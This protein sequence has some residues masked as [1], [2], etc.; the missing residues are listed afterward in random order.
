MFISPKRKNT[1]LEMTLKSFILCKLDHQ[2]PKS[3]KQ[4]AA[5]ELET[6]SKFDLLKNWVPDCSAQGRISAKSFRLKTCPQG[7]LEGCKPF[8]ECP[9]WD[10]PIW[11]ALY[12]TIPIQYLIFLR[13]YAFVKRLSC[14]LTSVDTDQFAKFL[15]WERLLLVNKHF[16]K[17]S[18][19]TK[20]LLRNI[21]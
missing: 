3:W 8:W 5:H 9:V 6:T 12:A 10:R 7:V 21:F 4:I 16:M 1:I 18:F 20:C 19:A 17:N 2:M 11:D 13:Y 15:N 14:V